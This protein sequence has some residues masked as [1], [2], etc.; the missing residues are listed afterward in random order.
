[1]KIKVSKHKLKFTIKVLYEEVKLSNTR[2]AY[3]M[4][5]PNTLTLTSARNN[6]KQK[7][8]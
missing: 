6:C 8:Q 3:V 1:M 7:F 4:H 5:V 2:T